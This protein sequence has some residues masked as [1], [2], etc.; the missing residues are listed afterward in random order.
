MTQTPDTGLFSLR[1]G[2]SA[3]TALMALAILELFVMPPLL[4]A[5]VISQIHVSAVYALSLL[6]GVVAVGHRPS[7]RALAAVLVLAALVSHVL[8]L[9][10]PGRDAA[11]ADSALAMIVAGTFGVLVLAHALGKGPVTYHRVVG[12]VVAFLLV[13]VAWARAFHILV[14]L[15][16]DALSLPGGSARYGELVYYSF[17]TLTTLG[18]G[19]PVHPLA[20]SMTMAE[21]LTGLL[22]P[23]ILIARLVNLQAPAGSEPKG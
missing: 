1:M 2:D 21:A 7:V 18:Y 6:A 23:P 17:A 3:R 10:A 11:V 16:P 14:L 13:G 20:R 8:L 4:D 15:R 9:R 5:G 22:Y 12:A 19:N